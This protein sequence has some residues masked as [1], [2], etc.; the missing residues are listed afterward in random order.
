MIILF[1]TGQSTVVA[2]SQ[3]ALKMFNFYF[4]LHFTE[5]ILFLHYLGEMDLWVFVLSL[6]SLALLSFY[7]FCFITRGQTPES[8]QELR[9]S[10]RQQLPLVFQGVVHHTP[11][12]HLVFGVYKQDDKWRA[13]EPGKCAGWNT[14]LSWALHTRLYTAQLL[15]YGDP[16]V[17]E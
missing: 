15:R 13:L 7:L 16:P 8:L 9:I 4:S 3:T 6:L 2:S 5:R 10:W 11:T 1:S 12:E 17:C 14:H